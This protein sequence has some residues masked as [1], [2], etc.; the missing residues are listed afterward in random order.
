MIFGHLITVLS[1]MDISSRQNISKEI[2]EVNSPIKQLI[3]LVASGPIRVLTVSQERMLREKSEGELHFEDEFAYSA[4]VV[5]RC[6]TQQRPEAVRPCTAHP[7]LLG[8]TLQKDDLEKRSQ[9][10]GDDDPDKVTPKKA[11]PDEAALDEAAPQM[12]PLHDRSRSQEEAIPKTR[13]LPGRGRSRR[14][15]ASRSD[16]HAVAEPRPTQVA[17]R[18]SIHPSGY[19]HAARTGRSTGPAPPHRGPQ[20]PG[21]G[22]A[23][24][25]SPAS[26]RYIPLSRISA[27]LTGSR[28]RSWAALLGGSPASSRPRASPPARLPRS[29]ASGAEQHGTSG[30]VG[31]W[32][33]L[34]AKRFEWAQARGGARPPRQA[35]QRLPARLMGHS[36]RRD[37]LPAV[38]AGLRQSRRPRHGPGQ[39]P[40]VARG[41][42]NPH[43]PW[44]PWKSEGQGRDR[45][46]QPPGTEQR[47]FPADSEEAVRVSGNVC[48]IQP[49]RLLSEGLY[50]FRMTV[51]PVED[52]ISYSRCDRTTAE[53]PGQRFLTHW[54]CAAAAAHGPPR[55]GPRPAP[56]WDAGP[57]RPRPCGGPGL[58]PSAADQA[59]GW[60][61]HAGPGRVRRAVRDPE[62]GPRRPRGR[63]TRR[64][65]SGPAVARLTVLLLRPLVA[66]APRQRPGLRDGGRDARGPSAATAGHLRAGPVP[67]ARPRGGFRRTRRR[68]TARDT[69][70]RPRASEQSPPDRGFSPSRPPAPHRGLGVPAAPGRAGVGSGS[71]WATGGDARRSGG[72]PEERG[73]QPRT[74]PAPPTPPIRGLG[75]PRRKQQ[76]LPRDAPAPPSDEAGPRGE[77]GVAASCARRARGAGAGSSG[78]VAAAQPGTRPRVPLLPRTPPRPRAA[79]P[80]GLLH[81]AGAAGRERGFPRGRALGRRQPPAERSPFSPTL[82]CPRGPA[83]PATRGLA[84]WLRRGRA[85]VGAPRTAALDAPRGAPEETGRE[86]RASAEEAAG[87]ERLRGRCG[88]TSAWRGA[89]RLR[90]GL[91]CAPRLLRRSTAARGPR[92]GR[93]AAPAAAA[94]AGGTPPGGCGRPH[95]KWK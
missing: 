19:T 2:V 20:D 18:I 88:P 46:R 82:G 54:V 7:V 13:L 63:L 65:T 23:L 1:E 41:A 12:K 56:G 44:L 76:E 70:Q 32:C 78:P 62:R 9:E 29:R 57:R 6:E 38:D 79:W 66:R 50:R 95:R 11:A 92:P 87:K 90:V 61:P 34:Q 16:L 39:A 36:E 33:G 85:A 43:E 84:W 40:R 55:P 52:P 93:S 69:R 60:R 48:G 53:G 31:G 80:R 51:C 4:E 73:P 8:H 58:G 42:Q 89:G 83:P 15:R 94:P 47:T 74:P 10:S 35:Q 81:A 45:P 59:A 28:R 37:G 86:R 25:R 22:A 30:R 26:R 71:V 67:S 77:S 17:N 91:R 49:A 64:R 5:T 27:T 3:Q 24:T 75:A 72:R 68:A 21:A 14:R